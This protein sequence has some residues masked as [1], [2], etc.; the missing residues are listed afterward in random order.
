MQFEMQFGAVNDVYQAVPLVTG[1]DHR[2]S[3][4]SLKSPTR[5]AFHSL[6]S[7]KLSQFLVIFL[8]R[9]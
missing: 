2:P 4:R 3:P 7:D 5:L 9:G 6:Y 1:L 8:W